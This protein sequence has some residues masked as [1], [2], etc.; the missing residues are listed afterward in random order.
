M[1]QKWWPSLL[2]WKV[3]KRSEVL[4]VC[5]YRTSNHLWSSIHGCSMLYK[6]QQLS[7]VWES[8]ADVQISLAVDEVMELL[9]ATWFQ[10]PLAQL[11]PKDVDDLV[12]FLLEYH[13]FVKV[14]AEIDQFVEGLLTM[15]FLGHLRKNPSLWQDVLVLSKD[16]LTPGL[17]IHIH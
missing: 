6:M 11:R 4:L 12:G 2:Q 13:L 10:K 9:L 16:N 14:K 8:D 1:K 15:E 3:G 7:L 5:T 17:F